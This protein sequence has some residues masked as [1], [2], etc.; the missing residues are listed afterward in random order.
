MKRPWRVVHN[1]PNKR[2]LVRPRNH[3]RQVPKPRPVRT[4]IHAPSDD[5]WEI[6][7]A[8]LGVAV[9][10]SVLYG[11]VLLVIAYWPIF[12]I[13]LMIVGIAHLCKR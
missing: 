9:V 5:I 3:P 6:I 10:V 2:V 8:V 13:G 1:S 7:L 12:V 4:V 11:L